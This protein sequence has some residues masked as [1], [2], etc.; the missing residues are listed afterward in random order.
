MCLS[1]AI[2]HTRPITAQL[3]RLQWCADKSARGSAVRDAAPPAR[4]GS[5]GTG[6]YVPRD[7]LVVHS[8]QPG[9]SELTTSGTRMSNVFMHK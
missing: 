5:L 4:A 1:A 9:T 7:V 3:T 2:A 8:M 6:S